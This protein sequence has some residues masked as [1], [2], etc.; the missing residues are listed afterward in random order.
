[1]HNPPVLRSDL[2]CRAANSLYGGW[3]VLTSD[4]GVSRVPYIG[5]KGDYS[6]LDVV[7]YIGLGS[8]YDDRAHFTLT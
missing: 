8:D 7:D 2:R 4:A 5:Y 3:V 1:M 6:K